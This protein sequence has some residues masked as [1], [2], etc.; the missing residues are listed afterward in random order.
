MSIRNNMQV[1]FSEELR[2]ELETHGSNLQ[3]QGKFLPDKE[4]LDTY[5]NVAHG[6]SY[7]FDQEDRLDVTF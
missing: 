2:Q 1:N 3:I 4:V 7:D 6:N 5:L